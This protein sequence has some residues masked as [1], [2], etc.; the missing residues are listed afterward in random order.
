MEENAR[1]REFIER[2]LRHPAFHPFLDDLSRDP[3]IAEAAS[4]KVSSKSKDGR[5]VNHNSDAV[6]QIQDRLSHDESPSK[7]SSEV[8]ES[9]SG[10][11]WPVP[12]MDIGTF[13][14]PN[15][16]AVLD[17]PRIERLLP[18]EHRL[19]DKD[20]MLS[21]HTDF[22]LEK[23]GS[24]ATY[25]PAV[26]VSE[27]S[28]SLFANDAKGPGF[29][30]FDDQTSTSFNLSHY[31]QS[32]LQ[33]SKLIDDSSLPANLQSFNESINDPSFDRIRRICTR[34]NPIYARI[35]SMTAH[36]EL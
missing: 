16:F 28:G 2:L 31:S 17:L 12:D 36:L 19:F 26:D 5:S 21:V 14:S 10:N 15:V 3:A 27:K 35:S 32:A 24:D 8:K 20:E 6:P 34:M 18:E 13:E 23:D 22:G 11:P 30:L 33:A 4:Q 7:D 25:M 29:D 9:L 1:S